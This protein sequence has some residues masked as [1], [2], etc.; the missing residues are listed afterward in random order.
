MDRRELLKAIGASGLFVGFPGLA[1]AGRL[2]ERRIPEDKGITPEMLAA[3]RARGDRRVYRGAKRFA[4][5]MPCGGVAAGQ[6]YLLGDGT[7]GGWHVDGRLNSTGWGSDNYKIR[8]QP[9][10]LVQGFTVFVDGGNRADGRRLEARLCD[11]ERGG[12]FEGIEF[13][14]EYP[15]AE[16]RYG[17]CRVAE[18][19]LEVT[20]R[21][22]SP[23][24]PLNA[25]DSGL[26]CTIL[27]FTVKNSTKDIVHGH[28]V[29]YLENG[30]DK[31]G[32][33]EVP[34]Q[35]RNRALG[36]KG[37]S[38]VVMDAMPIEDAPDAR[39]DRLL[40]DFEG[41]DYKGWEVKGEA[42]GN[43]PAKGTFPHQQ[44][45][46]GFEGAGLV[47][48]YAD[49]DDL[50][51]EMVSEPFTI[52]R[53]YL[54]LLVGGGRHPGRACV[55]LLVD[56]KAV[57]TAT[58]RN[59]E[60]LELKAWDVREFAGKHGRVQIIDAQ[61]G[62]WGHINADAIRLVDRLP[63]EAK[64][65]RPDSLTY[66]TLALSAAG[67]PLV[68]V[69]PDKLGTADL[70]NSRNVEEASREGAIVG[71]VAVP[72]HVG[73][74]ESREL[75]FLVTWC[76]PNLHTGQG[77]M[78]SN[79][80]KD[81]DEV[82]GYVSGNLERLVRETELF[83]RT[84][85]ED[86]TLPWW[87]ASRLFMPTANL[88]TG[89]AQWWKN[90][91]LW[92]WEGVGCCSGTCTHVWNYSHAEARLFPELARS[93]RVMQDL[94]SG[95][96]EGTGRVAFR[97]EVNGGAAYAG[98]GQSGTVLKCWREHLSSK[99]D[100][101]LRAN[102]PKIKK[103]LEYQIERDA[104][105]RGPKGA[106][107]KGG[108]PDGIIDVTQHNTYDINFEGPNT[109][110]GALYLA[111][112]LAGARMAELIGEKDGAARYRALAARGREFSEKRL[113][114]D[115]YFVQQ[116]PEDA[117]TRFQYGDGCLTDQL[118]GQN[119]A[120]CVGL[121]TV[122]DE[123]KVRSALRAVFRHNWSPAVGQYNAKYPPERWFAEGR[124]GGLFIC[125][126]PRGGRPGEPVRYRDEVWTGCEYQVAGGMLWEGIVD[127]ALVI[128][129]AIEDR[130]DGAAHNPWNEVECGDHYARAMASYGAY[131]ALCGFMYDGPAGVI[132]IAPRL[133]PEQF[134][135][136]FAAA[137]GWGL[138]S[139]AREGGAQTNRF[140]VRSGSLRVTTVTAEVP[141]G[142]SV[143][144]ARFS[145]RDG[146]Q[147]VI[148]SQK[149][150]S[151]SATYP[152]RLEV[153]QGDTLSVVW[154]S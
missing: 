84:W 25:K 102:W 22:G 151:V 7:L 98:D 99:D 130:Y 28:L 129:K 101:F 145:I 16:V 13:V 6:L 110:V 24:V 88:A 19:P 86:T 61:K 115:G 39:A 83:H 60:K 90:G 96:E 82:A 54:T 68:D 56:G 113:F 71:G 9:R 105:A 97:G 143:A 89:T 76:F 79:W 140:E 108:E 136:F 80:F 118:F 38:T 23:F 124:E 48:S 1:G 52:D 125:T 14:G 104:L 3:L 78:Y 15:L 43:A 154:T 41:P 150:T 34:T 132:G 17:G 141:E 33:G 12:S 133:N 121:G 139:Q 152:D 148:P 50:L 137:E 123:E 144:K 26:P 49:N 95:F 36:R 59:E 2:P 109:F 94:G 46:S 147:F 85:Y 21:A 29:G 138:V 5:G 107:V 30:I 66:G 57:R 77:V 134:A 103:V 31:G 92:G 51:G 146:I 65:P 44:P 64:R 106:E 81:A 55:N 63:A 127:E 72:F 35:R 75:T 122:Y 27:R 114:R 18:F 91:R 67:T 112:L 45:V 40:F 117:S 126:W 142:M 128:V 100:S 70:A 42:F 62:A 111:S 4:L 53:N 73:P 120:R 93:T 119:W 135:A 149:G 87:L 153:R 10:E 11:A 47:N 58:G 37:L 116:I 74:G 69:D 20:L 131:Q 32:P 8:P